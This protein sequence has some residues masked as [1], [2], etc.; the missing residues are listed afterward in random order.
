MNKQERIKEYNSKNA[1]YNITGIKK[2][3]KGHL[4]YLKNNSA[5]TLGELYQ[6]CSNAKWSSYNEILATYQPKEVIGLVDSSMSY[7]ITLVASNGDTLW[8][9]KANNYLV[10]VV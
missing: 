5:K 4:D 2:V 7:S 6:S 9:T 8:I 10:E 3:S 1:L